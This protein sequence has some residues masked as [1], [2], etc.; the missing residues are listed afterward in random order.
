MVRGFVVLVSA[1]AAVAAQAQDP[2][3]SKAEAEAGAAATVPRKTD[4]HAVMLASRSAPVPSSVQL[5]ANARSPS[6]GARSDAGTTTSAT[7]TSA[8][9]CSIVESLLG[10]SAPDVRTYRPPS[11]G[12]ASNSTSWGKAPYV[13][14]IAHCG[15]L[16]ILQVRSHSRDA[17]VVQRARRL[18]GPDGAVLQVEALRSR[19][20]RASWT[21]NVIVA[22]A[23]P[24]AKLSKLRLHLSGED[25]RV[26]QVEAED[27][28]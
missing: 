16:Y 11:S 20:L 10:G 25:G 8:S 28:P 9:D 17:W 5:S 7:P 18:E 21:V 1:L 4:D 13:A 26:V 14:A 22:K 27:V 6:P 23:A 3:S 2:V 12:L 24:G 19:T 15:D